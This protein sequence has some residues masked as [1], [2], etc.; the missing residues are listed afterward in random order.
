MQSLPAMAIPL[1]LVDSEEQLRRSV[2]AFNQHARDYL[3]RTQSILR[4]TS[5]WVWDP[6]TKMFGPSKFIGYRDMDFQLYEAAQQG[7][8]TGSTFDGGNTHRAIQSLLGEFYDDNDLA[9]ML[10]AWGAQLA[11]SSVF[12][13]VDEGKW[14]FAELSLAD[15]LDHHEFEIGKVYNRRQD[16]HARFGGQSRGGISTPANCPFIFLFTGDTGQQYGYR[17][18]WSKENVFLYTG[19]GQTGDMEFRAGNKAIRDHIQDGEQLLLFSALGKG[20]GYRFLGEFQCISWEYRESP[21]KDRTPRKV[22]VFHLLQLNRASAEPY[23]GESELTTAGIDDGNL[24]ELRQ[25]ALQAASPASQVSAGEARHQYYLR[26][27]HVRA[28]VLA[29]AA[30]ICESC[31]QPAPFLRADG[32]PYLEP[33]HTRRLSDGGPDDPRWVAG[34]CPTCHRR[35][36]SGCDGHKINDALKRRLLQIEAGSRSIQAVRKK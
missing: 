32:T 25:K 19:E 16:I 18:G 6:N 24:A 28:Y 20:E 27:V 13:D 7:S 3:D 4:Q 15:S 12:D 1:H 35:I 29:R 23:A 17:D 21:D 26:S 31:C 10:K 22:I 34:I 36:H 8:T 5:Y 11:G 30:G 33:H 2:A 9:V 14:R